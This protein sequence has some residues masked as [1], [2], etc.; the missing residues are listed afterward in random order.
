M[1]SVVFIIPKLGI[2]GV[3]RALVN[4]LRQMPPDKFAVTVLT[5]L[6]GGELET[7]VPRRI[8]I[9]CADGVGQQESTRAALSG[10]LRKVGNGVFF[11]FA[12]RIYHKFGSHIIGRAASAEHFDI[13]VAFA[14]G[15]ATWY[16]AKNIHA[17]TKIAFVHTD[18]LQA[19]YN[20]TQERKIYT[21]YDKIFFG[22]Q[23]AKKAFLSLM[24]ELECKAAILP[25]SIDAQEILHL[26]QEKNPYPSDNRCKLL[27]VGRLSHEKGVDKI[28][29][30]LRMFKDEGQKVVWYV[31]GDGP[32]RDLLLQR[33]RELGVEESLVLT[34][35]Q[36]N[37]YTYM[38]CCDVYVQP[39]NYEGY[40]IALAEARVLCKPI[41]ACSF[42]GADEQLEN[43]VDGFVTGMDVNELFPALLKLVHDRE[44][45]AAFSHALVQKRDATPND[46][47]IQAWW[48]WLETL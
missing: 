8:T 41:V 7:Q 14:D 3:E 33:T 21:A 43:G 27:T 13:A 5:F 25:N 35:A 16:T 6:P 30:L 2:G 22:S 24:P 48:V 46:S 19:G 23:S 31:V 15:L 9:R 36:K 44:K 11:N 39:S 12:K 42:S 1:K 34:G 28:P 26:A 4:L 18:V 40:C 29:Q 47:A 10:L 37:P 32:E 38:R 20:A 45:R 17:P